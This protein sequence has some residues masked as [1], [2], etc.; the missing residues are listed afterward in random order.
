M[1]TADEEEEVRALVV[2][3]EQRE[4]ARHHGLLAVP[5]DG[6]RQTTLEGKLDGNGGRGC[7]RVS[8]HTSTIGSLGVQRC[9]P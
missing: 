8:G 4:R 9:S 5:L 7:R 2:S 6:D 1:L 3:G